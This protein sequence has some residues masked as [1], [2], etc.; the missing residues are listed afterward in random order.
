MDSPGQAGEG[1]VERGFL[2][3]NSH[4]VAAALL[5]E[6]PQVMIQ[7]DML[8][9]TLSENV[10]G[11]L[12]SQYPNVETLGLWAAVI[13]I[14]SQLHVYILQISGRSQQQ[15]APLAHNQRGKV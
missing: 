14:D 12:S 1:A 9:L 6:Q 8:N 10:N 11:I 5:G 2:N 7:G 13:K 3:P 4:I 15:S